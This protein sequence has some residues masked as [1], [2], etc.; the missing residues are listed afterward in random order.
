[1]TKKM[2]CNVLQH[3]SCLKLVHEPLVMY[4]LDYNLYTES[5]RTR[6]PKCIFYVEFIATLYI[7]T[8]AEV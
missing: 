2:K 5:S 4:F 6:Q 8:H 3:C 1:M 7:Q